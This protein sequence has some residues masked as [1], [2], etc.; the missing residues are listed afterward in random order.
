M[1]LSEVWGQFGFWLLIISITIALAGTILS[2]QDGWGRMFAD[3]TLILLGPKLRRAGL[4]EKG[5]E[6]KVKQKTWWQKVISERSKLKD[7]YA[8]IFGAA[9]PLIVFFLVRDPVS[10]LSIAGTVAAVHTPVVV[11]LTL[12]LN[13]KRLPSTLRPGIFSIICMVFSGLFFTAFAVY[14]FATL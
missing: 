10:I 9:I 5:Q 2:N 8:V 7:T 6:D 13:M 3:G 1:L 12:Y 11:F 14:H 4:L